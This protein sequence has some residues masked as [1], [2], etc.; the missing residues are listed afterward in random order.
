MAR[1]FAVPTYQSNKRSIPA[2]NTTSTPDARG[3]ALEFVRLEGLH[4]GGLD[5]PGCG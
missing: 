2:G 3:T 1:S 5:Q 4:C